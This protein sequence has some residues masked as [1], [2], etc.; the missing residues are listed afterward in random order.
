PARTGPPGSGITGMRER[1]RALGGDLTAGPAP[2]GGFTV[3]ATL[4]LARTTA[5]EGPRR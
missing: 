2:G 5:T 4:P 1:A 3:R